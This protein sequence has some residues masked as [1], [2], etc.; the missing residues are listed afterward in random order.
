LN[1]TLSQ[2]RI[3]FPSLED[4]PAEPGPRFH[5][6]SNNPKG[7]YDKDTNAAFDINKRPTGATYGFDED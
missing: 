6:K 4:L 5:D 2:A 1:P 3:G 7:W